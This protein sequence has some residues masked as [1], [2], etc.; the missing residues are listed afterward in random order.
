MVWIT[1]TLAWQHCKKFGMIL[2]TITVCKFYFYSNDWNLLN[3]QF[4]ISFGGRK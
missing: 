1:V 4:N 2:L 3:S